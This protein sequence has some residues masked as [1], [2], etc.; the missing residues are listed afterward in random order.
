M[1]C[2]RQRGSSSAQPVRD[3]VE[4]ADAAEEPIQHSPLAYEIIVPEGKPQDRLRELV[5]FDFDMTRTFH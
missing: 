2:K 4:H 3:D 1:A 5:Q